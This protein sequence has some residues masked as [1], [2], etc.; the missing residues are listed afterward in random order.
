MGAGGR[1]PAKPS[2]RGGN[3]LLL[4]GIA[5]AT[6]A[7]AAV[8]DAD[9]AE[10][11]GR[12]ADAVA[13]RRADYDSLATRES[14]T[15]YL[16]ALNAAGLD[17]L[18]ETEGQRVS[19]R[20]SAWDLPVR[21][22]ARAAGRLGRPR[23]GAALLAVRS[24]LAARADRALLL[25][26]AGLRQEAAGVFAE[27]RTAPRARGGDSPDDLWA[28]GRAAW[29]GGAFEEASGFFQT[30]YRESLENQDARL[31][32]ARLFQE[33]YQEN[34]AREELADARKLAPAHP[35]VAL[36]AAEVDLDAGR[37]S[38]AEADA[39]DVLAARPHDA[40]AAAV[41][42][43]LALIADRP[44]EAMSWL[45]EPLDRNPADRHARSMLAA[46][47][48]LSGDSTGWVRERDRVL[49]EDP[50]RLEVFLDLAHI[51]EMS[52]RNEEAFALYD[53]VLARDPDNP[54]A[55]LAKGL[56]A[57]R[58]GD[59]TNARAWLEKG[60]EGDP[61]NI[62]AYNQLELLDKM[63][64][65]A[66]QRTDHFVLR[67]EA[68]ADSLLAPLLGRSLESI[69]RD[70]VDRHGWE[71]PAPTV[72]EVLP[73]HDWF[74]ARVTGLPWIGGIPAVCF[75][76]VVAMDSP[77]TLSGHSNWEEILRHE[78]GHVLALGM[79][80]KKVPHW[81][82]EGLSVHLE[83]FPRGPTWDENLAAAYLDGQLIGIDSLSIG[84]TRPKSQAQRLLA[85]HEA[86]I[87]VGDLVARH[88]WESIPKIL[89]GIG[90]GRT[91]A[92]ALRE[93]TGES[94]PAFCDRA[95]AVVRERAAAIP[96]WPSPG[97]V[98]AVRLLALS[99]SKPGDRDMLEQ[100]AL[101]QFQVGL[102]EEAQRAAE[103]LLEVSPGNPRANGI[104]GLLI[105]GGKEPGPARPLLA[106]AFDAGSRDL[107][108]ILSL[109]DRDL[110]L[111]DTALA[112]TRYDR[113]LEVYPEGTP[114]RIARARTRLAGGDR[115]GA[116]EDYRAL[117]RLDAT[118]AE[119]AIE[120][121]QLEL[122]DDRG[123]GAAS[124]LDYAVD[125]LPLDATVEA[126]RGQ[127]YLLLGREDEAY[128]LFQRAHKLDVRSVE[129]MVGLASYYLK[130]GDPEEAIYFA[131]LAL[132]YDPQHRRA[133]AVRERAARP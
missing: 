72:V 35:E 16:L 48:Y 67:Y 132:K 81:F 7:A 13:L 100:L 25:D 44:A 91:F 79:T 131:D 21:L 68:A 130:R 107:P 126:L 84:F 98:R 42:A 45:R 115:E 112:L 15:A 61:F 50:G 27:I 36:A 8:P 110:A 58:E 96:V 124:A 30:A 133:L 74:S 18:L 129:A 4:V 51:L 28:R 128:R 111:G 116:R 71:P 77:R 56:L 59:E 99:E 121:A 92:A 78:F 127:A 125:I 32:L 87:V 41:L 102:R 60:F 33:K 119:G 54:A 17:S 123:E 63:D 24:S 120:L 85:Y 55:F 12:W 66:S 70:L 122:E 22:A 113:A 38:E 109:A 89:R 86:G 31:D 49:A 52:R 97:R 95:L 2:I 80:R 1:I 118:A 37:L 64:T 20:L 88:G 46:A 65:F 106:E 103:K 73:S 23:A 69:R 94:Y 76:D 19:S 39:R 10:S 57:M 47:N 26:R 117:L 62:R 83:R 29:A 108:V 43:A 9:K 34:L 14:A 6:A 75:G 101:A 93:A 5:L 82:T 114:A 3:L 40:G 53:A 104:L 11:E 90:E 105:L